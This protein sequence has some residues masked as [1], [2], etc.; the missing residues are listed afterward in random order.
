MDYKFNKLEKRLDDIEKL[1]LQ[2]NEK[3]DKLNDNVLPECKK[4]GS[5]IDFV[6][7][8]YETVKHPL[9]FICDKIKRITG[10]NVD[11]NLHTIED[12]AQ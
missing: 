4:M 9:G 6:E 8:V 10:Y 1:L 7:N 5:H 3:L 2:L 12:S 11:Y